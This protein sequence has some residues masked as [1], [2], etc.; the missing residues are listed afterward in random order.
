MAPSVTL[1]QSLGVPD[2]P[3]YVPSFWLRYSD[4]MSFGERLYNAAIA[5]AELIVSKVAFR[6]AEQQMLEDLYTY[7]G[8][9]NC[10]P[11]DALRQAVQLT[12]V[13]GHH[14]VSYAR[15]YPPNVVQVAGMHIRPQ[16]CASVDRVSTWPLNSLWMILYIYTWQQMVFC[17]HFF[18]SLY[19]YRTANI[20]FLN[21]IP[22]HRPLK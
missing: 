9:R 10:P 7:P 20:S 22:L 18:E 11:L 21:S 6:S 8:H 3:A 4:S 12:L 19:N 13:N 2:H 14:S 15:P 17:L 16:K 1:S 5:A